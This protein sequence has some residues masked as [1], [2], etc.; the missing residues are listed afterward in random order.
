MTGYDPRCPNCYKCSHC[1]GNGTVQ[2]AESGKKSDE[3]GHGF[4]FRKVTCPRCN[5]RGGIVGS[6]TH[7]H[8]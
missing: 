4:F 2:Q 8:R 5:G 1:G 7:D 6:G 3:P